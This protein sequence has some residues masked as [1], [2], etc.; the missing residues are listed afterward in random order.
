MYLQAQLTKMPLIHQS[1]LYL[2]SYPLSLLSLSHQSAAEERRLGDE[3]ALRWRRLRGS[4]GSITRRAAAGG[5]GAV[6]A[7]AEG[8]RRL[9][10]GGIGSATR[11]TAGG[12]SVNRR[13]ARWRL[14]GSCGGVTLANRR[15][16]QSAAT[17]AA[18][19]AR[20]RGGLPAPARGTH[21]QLYARYEL[22]L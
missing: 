9:G 7:A 12:G 5:G 6:V 17:A 1:I 13:I 8:W 22:V 21:L 15:G 16:E 20:L 4:G 10:D 19:V 11:R 14:R 18:A 3:A 2:H